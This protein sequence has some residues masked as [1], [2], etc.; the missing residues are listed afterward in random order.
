MQIYPNIKNIEV[1]GPIEATYD[2][3]EYIERRHKFE[4]IAVGIDYLTR[5]SP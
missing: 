1:E 5:R 4:E 3:D 2:I